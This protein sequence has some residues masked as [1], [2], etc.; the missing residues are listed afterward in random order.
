MVERANPFNRVVVTILANEQ[1]VAAESRLR[2]KR[3]DI[4]MNGWRDAVRDIASSANAELRAINVRFTEPES[5]DKS[6]K[7]S[8]TFSL[9]P[10]NP[11][12]YRNAADYPTV[13]F[14]MED[15]YTVSVR[16]KVVIF[17]RQI[18]LS[19][20]IPREWLQQVLADYLAE[21]AEDARK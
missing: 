16:S 8:F 11:T 4:F 12:K 6:A 17:E 21:A 7:P 20:T 10:I 14:T 15:A 18:P 5:V 13:V 2:T 3:W 19:D 9:T 1:K